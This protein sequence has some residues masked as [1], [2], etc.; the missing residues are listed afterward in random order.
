MERT[1]ARFDH[2]KTEYELSTWCRAVSC[3]TKTDSA[4]W[5]ICSW[6]TVYN[7][8]QVVPVDHH[9]PGAE[10]G[11]E[12]EGTVRRSYRHFAWFISLKGVRMPETLPGDDEPDSVVKIIKESQAWLGSE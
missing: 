10:A 4:G 2:K 7:R 12:N 8:D 11:L 9:P 6:K 5:K 3:L 1:I